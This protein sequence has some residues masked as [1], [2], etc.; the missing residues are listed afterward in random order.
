VR[1]LQSQLGEGADWLL[2][3]AGTKRRIVLEVS[4]T[5]EGPFERRVREKSRQAALAALRG[6]PAACVVRFLEPKALLAE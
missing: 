5:D 2:E 6:A 1:R 3:E 4:G